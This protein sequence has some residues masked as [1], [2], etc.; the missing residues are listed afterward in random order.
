MDPKPEPS[1]AELAATL[2]ALYVL[3]EQQ[4]LD[5]ATRILRGAVAAQSGYVVV[6]QLRALVRRVLNS[7]RPGMLVEA[8]VDASTVEG[9][10]AAE[11][12]VSIAVARSGAHGGGGSGHVHPLLGRGGD[13]PFDLSMPHGERA[14]QAIRDDVVSS[15][16]DV[17]RRL[18]RL[19][20]DIYK[21]IA[22]HG[23][24]RQVL[25]NGVTPAQAQAMAWRVFTEHGVTGFVD[26]SGREWSLSAYVEMAV[27]TASTR[28]F[29]SSHLDR[30]VALG[31][32]YFTVPVT[33]HTCPKCFPW[34]G[35][36][37]TLTPVTD[38]VV[39]VAGTIA[40]ATAAG[41]WHPNCFPGFVP[42]SAPSGVRAADSRW[43][44]GE[45]V[46]IHTAAGNELSVTPNHPVLTPEG[47]VAAGD[48][49]V[50]HH[51][52]RHGANVERVDVV[53]PDDEQVEAPIGD[54]YDA[55]RHARGVTAVSVPSSA[56]QFHGDGS[57]A[58]VEVVLVDR[59]LPDGRESGVSEQ[60]SDRALLVGGVRFELLPGLGALD[61]FGVGPLDTSH[62]L[63]SV[64]RQGGALCARHASETLGHGGA[65]VS[66]DAAAQEP[67]T[68]GALLHSEVLADLTLR[69]PGLPESDRFGDALSG[70][71]A[72]ATLRGSGLG[73][74]ADDA[75]VPNELPDPGFADA[76]GGR[77]LA[78]RFAGDVAPDQ[79]VMVERRD[80]AG[81]V[82]NLQTGDGWYV[83]SSVVV[84]NCKHPLT[85]FF[86]GH[87]V[88]PEPREW[89]AEDQRLYDL[90][91]QQRRLE[92]AVRKAKRQFEYATTPEVAADA[93]RRVR[94][95]Q[96]KL[97]VFVAENGLPRQS[98]REQLHLSDARIKLPVPQ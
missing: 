75:S 9:R 8:M 27:R 76:N 23:A 56:E 80:F 49:V 95:A 18:T 94:N 45:L 29:N 66:T 42:V 43:Y 48:L 3:A 35:K 28:A 91:Q 71:G 10:R 85:A 73:R 88:L 81:H 61:E 59:L 87:T 47:W 92:L 63:V 97:R 40:E 82:Y 98:R 60:S 90:S 52:I 58:D 39:P 12:A 32:T 5:G 57:D 16:E 67:S 21:G 6:G 31:V 22:P 50:G 77:D 37:L 53:R 70:I 89:T 13:G 79:V 65:E 72:L 96:R 51:V 25:D 74:G 19:P 33:G 68:D 20:D 55:L 4:L 78:A 1:S 54:V 34:Q 84:H 24:I 46:I 64:G 17:R 38:P 83:A 11:Q 30:M 62:G 15:L 44:E 26:R 2:I 14:A 7:L 69:H 86:P 41:L 36:V 93:K